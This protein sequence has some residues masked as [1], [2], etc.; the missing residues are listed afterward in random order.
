MKRSKI[1]RAIQKAIQVTEAHNFA[2]P[3]FAYWDLETWQKN[4]EKIGE[5]PALMLGW[6]V[7][8]FNEGRFESKGAA[9]FTLRNGDLNDPSLGTPYAEKIIY[10]DHKT[11]QEIPFHFHLKK[12][13]D[14]IN[15]AGGTLLLE[16]Y[17]RTSDDR[18]DQNSAV[19]VKMDGIFHTFAPGEIVRVK[20]GGSITLTPGLFHRFWADQDSGELVIGE[21]SSI[22]DDVSDNIF[23]EPLQRFSEIEEDE[24][25]LYPLCNEYNKLLFS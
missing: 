14:I 4:R 5:I 20:P 16:L 12:T 8:D 9:L 17:N 25:P 3:E 13:E 7:T 15:R 23:L 19:S 18:L 21:V 24:A 2:L 6:D 1:N 11:G 10:V 22:N